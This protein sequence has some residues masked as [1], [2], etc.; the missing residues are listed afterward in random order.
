MSLE[1]VFRLKNTTP[2][3]INVIVNEVITKEA[4]TWPKTKNFDEYSLDLRIPKIKERSMTDP[5]ISRQ[6]DSR[7]LLMTKKCNS[8]RH[9]SDLKRV[10][11]GSDIK[12]LKRSA[13]TGGCGKTIG[14]MLKEK[15]KPADVFSNAILEAKLPECDKFMVPN[16]SAAE[17]GW[18]AQN[19][20]DRKWKRSDGPNQRWRRPKNEC[21]IVEFGRIFYETTG[22][23]CFSRAA[24]AS[25][26][27][28][29]PG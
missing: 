21:S 9:L 15:E 19:P 20:M 5:P 27:N 22:V 10:L 16:T 4:K 25:L 29:K 18:F 11:E 28:G 3:Q 26:F 1:S 14:D 12:K 17:V 13:S 2:A 24:Q 6:N 7:V 8:P 23:N